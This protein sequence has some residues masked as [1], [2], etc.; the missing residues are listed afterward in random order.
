MWYHI[1]DKRSQLKKTMLG[2]KFSRAQK[3]FWSARYVQNGGRP[4]TVGG[5]R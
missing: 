2:S 3:Q 4:A 1:L 5:A